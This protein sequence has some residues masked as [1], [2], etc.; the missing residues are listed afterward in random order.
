MPIASGR[1]VN[2]RFV[3]WICFAFVWAIVAA[4]VV[5]NLGAS[6]KKLDRPLER[7]YDTDDPQFRPSMASCSARPSSTATASRCWLNGDRIFAAMLADIR[8]ARPHDHLRDLHL[9][10]RLDRPASS[11]RRCPSARAPA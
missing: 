1:P 6:E 10:G 4:V 9:L 3:F 7:L 5:A 8:R 2:G 11:P